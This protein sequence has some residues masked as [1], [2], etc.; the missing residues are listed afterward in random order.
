MGLE[1]IEAKVQKVWIKTKRKNKK[2]E[3]TEGSAPCRVGTLIVFSD[4]PTVTV[5][6]KTFTGRGTCARFNFKHQTWSV[7]P[8]QTPKFYK[9]GRM[10]TDTKGVPEWQ[11]ATRV[12]SLTTPQLLAEYN[13]KFVLQIFAGH[14]AALASEAESMMEAA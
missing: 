4:T 14:E 8:P 1:V 3:K 12:R 13:S 5:N 6:G 9:S 11:D 10:I 7:E 2:G